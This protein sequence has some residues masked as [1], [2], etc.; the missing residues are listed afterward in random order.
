M[1]SENSSATAGGGVWKS[2]NL[3]IWEFGNPEIWRSGDLEIWDFGDLG[4]W[5]SRNWRSRK[6][7]KYK[8]SQFKSV[9]PKMSARSALVGKKTSEA[10]YPWT[11]KNEKNTFFCL[12]PLVGQWALFTRCGPLLLS[13]R[14][15]G[16]GT[17]IPCI[18]PSKGK[19]VLAKACSSKTQRIVKDH[20]L[21]R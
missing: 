12:F 9:L 8:F 15:G 6:S 14:G 5:K 1:G 21:P 18:E 13:T 20:T 19:W 3:E 10:F 2:G 17:Q 16:I 7:Q 11:G 4:T